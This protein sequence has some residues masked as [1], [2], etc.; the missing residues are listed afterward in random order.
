VS[1]TPKDPRRLKDTV[2]ELVK[3]DDGKFDLFLIHKVDQSDGLESGLPDKLC[4]C[5]GFCGEEYDSILQEVDL[6]GRA[7]IV[8]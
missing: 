8:F 1:R 5:F 2:L 4:M 3:R 6:R 7:T